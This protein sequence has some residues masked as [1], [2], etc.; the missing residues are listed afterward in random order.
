MNA[1]DIVKYEHANL[2]QVIDGL[3]EAEWRT[4]GV[5]GTSSVKDVVA[6][7]ASTELLIL[8]ALITSAR[9]AGSSGSRACSSIPGSSGTA[10][11][12]SRG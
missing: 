8:D 2:L 12:A 4:P 10:S 9:P 6:Y 11:R 3:P 5:C 1:S 7:L